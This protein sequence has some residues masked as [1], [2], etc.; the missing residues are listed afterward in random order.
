MTTSDRASENSTPLVADEEYLEAHP[1]L[2]EHPDC[3]DLHVFLYQFVDHEMSAQD[4]QRLEQ[5]IDACPDCAEMV[6]AEEQIRQVLQHVC[7]TNAPNSLRQK[8]L[9]GLHQTHDPCV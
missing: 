9:Q 2:K 4:R 6:C 3:A 8:I 1:V 7:E 5:H